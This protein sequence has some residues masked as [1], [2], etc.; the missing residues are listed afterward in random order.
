LHPHGAGPEA[1]A[2]LSE[3]RVRIDYRS[4]NHQGLCAVRG[5]G[6]FGLTR[7][8]EIIANIG[9]HL[10]QDVLNQVGIARQR[11]SELGEGVNFSCFFDVSTCG[12]LICV[13]RA[14]PTET[15]FLFTTIFVSDL[16][17]TDDT[18]CGS[19]FSCKLKI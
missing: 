6:E 15:A 16:L 19:L 13:S 8:V 5:A 17:L 14:Q 4:L 1:T 3:G 10:G 11:P 9:A 2:R 12:Y 18:E 7:L